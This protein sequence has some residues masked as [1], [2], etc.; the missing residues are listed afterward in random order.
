MAQPAWVKC[1]YY[2]DG[3][4]PQHQDIDRAYLIPQLL[5]GRQMQA[6]KKLCEECEKHH[7][8]KRKSPRIKR[9]LKVA[10]T[11][12]EQKRRS[13][14]TLVDVSTDGALVKLDHWVDFNKNETVKLQLFTENIFSNQ[15]KADSMTFSGRIRRLARKKQELAIIFLNE[16]VDKNMPTFT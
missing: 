5:D 11:N 3:L 4:C 12:Q 6:A 15:I 8:E 16:T 1:N 2:S 9:A 7:S 14:G 13:E 10:I